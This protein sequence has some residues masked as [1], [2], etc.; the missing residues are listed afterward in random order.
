[1]SST[2]IINS[3]LSATTGSSATEIDV[4]AAVNAILYADRAPERLWESQQTA[5]ASQ[6]SEINQ[7]QSESSTLTDQLNALQDTSGALYSVSATSS[8]TSVLSASAVAGT[9][10]GNHTVVVN[11]IATTANAYSNEVNPATSTLPSGSF[12]IVNSAGVASPAIPVGTNATNSTLAEL[13]A[14]INANSSL[15][16]TANVIT[17]SNGGRLSLVATT[18]GSA[19][20]FTIGAGATGLT[21]TQ[22]PG[23]TGTDAL[24]TV[25]GVPID[26]ASNTVTGAISGVTLNLASQSP[27]TTVNLTLTPNTGAI[28]T[29]VDSFVSA[30]NTLITDVNSQFA[31]SSATGTAG[32][33]ETDSVIQGF[34]QGLLDSTNYSAASGTLQTLASLGVATN[35]DG[36]LT[37]NTV[38]LANA[39]ANTPSA[40]Q[41]F[42]QGSSANGFAASLVTT[43][44]AYTDPTQGAF[45]VELSSISSAN[46]DLTNQTNTLELYLTAQQASLTTEYNNADIALAQLPQTLKQ[47]NALLNPNS[48]S[49]GS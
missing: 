34:Q 49:S 41:S 25:D 45:T 21:F 43:L 15:G 24:L 20:A 9:A 5:L 36:T 10:V 29:A 32:P 2:S 22:P 28:E 42:F 3:V 46:T 47:V 23:A 31:Y 17:D 12:T 35:R 14:T 16:V 8:D 38:T 11:S 39:V 7:L 13:A 30:Y 40:V 19:A 37:V 48:T 44:N 1:M 18:S 27:G 4:T 26:S 6:T 33:L